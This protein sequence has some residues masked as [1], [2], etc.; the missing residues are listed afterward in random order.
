M[1]T[2]VDT[3]A[4]VDKVTILIP[5]SSLAPNHNF[6]DLDVLLVC[7]NYFIVDALSDVTAS[8]NKTCP[9]FNDAGMKAFKE[10]DTLDNTQINLR[11]FLNLIKIQ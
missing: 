6:F 7:H 10:S 1:V 2:L 8:I 4:K 11:I 3:I 5:S 9:L